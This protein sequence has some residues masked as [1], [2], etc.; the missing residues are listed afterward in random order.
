M[1]FYAYRLAVRNEFSRIHSGRKLFL[2]YLLDAFITVEGNRLEWYRQNQNRIRAENYSGLHDFVEMRRQNQEQQQQQQQRPVN[3]EENI[4]NQVVEQVGRRVILPSTHHG[5]MRNMRQRYND[6]MAIVA[7]EGQPDLFITFSCNS[8]WPEI[9]N[10]I[11]D[12]IGNDDHIF[13]P[14]IEARVFKIKLDALLRDIT[15]NHIFGVPTAHV[16]VIEFQKRGHP[17]A[18][19]LV[20]LREEDKILAPDVIDH[21][22]SAE[23]PNQDEDPQLYE[24]VANFMLHGPC[25]QI[26]PNATCM[27]NEQN[28]CSKRFPKDFVAETTNEQNRF[29]YYRRRNDGRIIE[30]RCRN[31]ENNWITHAFDNR[32]VVPYNRYLLLKYNAHINVE[33]CSSIRAIKYLYKYIYKGHD[34][35]NVLIQDEI[36]TYIDCRYLSA[37]EA[38]WRL[39]KFEMQHLSHT[40]YRMQIHLPNEQNVYYEEGQEE[41]AVN[42]LDIHRTMLTEWFALNQR[43]EHAHNMLY[44]EVGK[45]Y[46]WENKQWTRRKVNYNYLLILH[47]LN[48]ILLFVIF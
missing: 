24:I 15:V 40:V 45:H 43:D 33:L 9:I 32:N 6:A 47:F 7:Q 48:E 4:D 27:Q 42:N 5:S 12:R 36:E 30:K 22:I 31:G 21:F 8:Q 26:N 29:P 23:I 19:I 46:R 38:A 11:R 14:D 1:E 28:M 2:Q 34:R 41:Q 35:A 37:Q 10:N 17:H 13:R 20:T 44:S 3:Q 25:G 16:H 39:F 18:H